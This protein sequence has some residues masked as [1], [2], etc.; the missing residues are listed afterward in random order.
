LK[1]NDPYIQSLDLAYH[2]LDP[3]QGLYQGL[4][5]AGEM[6]RLVTD[7]R[8]QAAMTCAPADT[9][10]YLRGL[11]VDRFGAHVRSIGWNGVAFRN[12]DEDLLFDMNPLVERDVQLLND[13]FGGAE[14]LDDVVRI[15]QQRPK[16]V[17]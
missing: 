8:I 6:R 17:N 9:R 16:D 2:D 11:F 4:V 15:L 14:T 5:Q 10:A 3:E 13:E 12:H 7:A 1:W